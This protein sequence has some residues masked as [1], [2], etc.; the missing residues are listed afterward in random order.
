MDWSQSLRLIAPEETLSIASL[1]LLLVAAWGGDKAAKLI[2]VLAVAALVAAGVLVAPALCGG[3]MGT[4]T[5]AFYGQFKADAFASYAKVLIYISAAVSLVVAPKFFDRFNAMRAEYPVLVLLAAIGMGMMVSATN[6]IT[7]YIGLEMNSLAAYVLAAFL[8]TDG[9]SAEAGLKYFVLGALA[10]GILLYGMSLT[11]GFAGTTS[12]DGISASMAH[13]LSNGALFGLVFVFAGL[14]FKI[15]AVPFHMWTPDVYEG[16][17]TPVTTLFATAPKVAAMALT[18]RV[19]IEAFG[20]QAH[21]WQ[22]IIVF[23]ALA[24]IVVGAL[25]AIRQ[26]NIKRLMAYSS[27]NN[28]GFMLVG[29]A[30]ATP[31]G[32]SAMLFYLAI[33]VAMSVGGFAMILMLTDEHGNQVEDLS[34]MAGLSRTRPGL[35]LGL[36]MIMFSLA[37]IPP[38]FGFWGKFLVFKAAVDGG[39]IALAALGFAASVIGAFYY[40]KVVKVMYFDEPADVVKGESDIWHKLILIGSCVVI[41]P[42]GFFLTKWLGHLADTAAAALFTAL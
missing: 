17:P 12:F 14:A 6:L 21:A 8:R 33:Y 30:V 25:G 28:V 1:I 10:S 22:Q 20:D 16:A 41:S 34:K 23:A 26:S 31:Q 3:A 18:M 5:F 32:I 7:L 2:S 29:L 35:A 4:E 15:S 36:A 37:G 39:M 42:L 40:L 13:G 19:A 9:R 11:Y 24:S 38:M 27:I